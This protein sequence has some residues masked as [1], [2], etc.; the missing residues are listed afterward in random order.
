MTSRRQ[1]EAGFTL[2]EVLVAL[3]VLSFIVVSLAE[4]TQFGFSASSVQARAEASHQDIEPVDRLLRRLVAGI[5]VPNDPELPGLVGARGGFVCIT[6]DPAPS[7]GGPPPRV[8]A[9]VATDAAH[10]LIVRW[11]PHV[12]ANRLLPGPAPQEDVLLQGVDRVVVSYL[13]PDRSGWLASWNRADLPRLIRI[14]LV[15][16]AGDPRRWPPIIAD[17]R[18]GR[19]GSAAVL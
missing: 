19:A 12:H 9:A 15:F 11:S 2:L 8:D 4:G 5:T 1:D 3:V 6:Q 16:A 7:A 14:Q 13:S 18:Q 17:T 10:Q